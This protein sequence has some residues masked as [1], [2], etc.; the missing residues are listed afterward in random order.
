MN[1]S[2]QRG[3]PVSVETGHTSM[4]GLNCGTPSTI[5]WP[6]LQQGIDAAVSVTEDQAA[7]AVHDLAH[8]GVDSGPCGAATVAALRAALLA[9]DGELHRDQLGLRPDST[10]VLLSTEGTPPGDVGTAA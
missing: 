6:Y 2:L 10:V 8:G 7:L 3:E 4:A 1:A 9:R 5:A